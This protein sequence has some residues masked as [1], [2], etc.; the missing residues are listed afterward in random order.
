[1]AERV[2]PC[3]ACHGKEG[4]ATPDGYY[5][6]IAGKPAGYLL[7]EL[8]NFRSGRRFFQ[9]MVYFTQQ[10]EEADLAE[11]AAYFASQRLPYPAPPPLKASPQALERAANH[12]QGNR[13]VGRFDDRRTLYG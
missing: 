13:R 11:I 10:R 3:T 9:Q 6:R 7:N 5:P 4:R 2:R 8:N 1:M 12:C